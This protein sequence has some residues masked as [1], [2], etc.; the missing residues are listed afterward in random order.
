M[1]TIIEKLYE[2]YCKNTTSVF[3]TN[4]VFFLDNETMKECL[5]FLI[6]RKSQMALTNDA[7][8]LEIVAM[9]LL[10]DMLQVNPE[11]ILT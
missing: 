6:Q 3:I 11:E 10:S 7:T 2:K 1:D 4:G 8:I 9:T 5:D